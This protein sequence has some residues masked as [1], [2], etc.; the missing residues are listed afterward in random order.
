MLSAGSGSGSGAQNAGKCSFRSVGWRVVG[1]P[2]RACRV[3]ISRQ[4]TWGFVEKLE[5]KLGKN[6]GVWSCGTEPSIQRPEDQASNLPFREFPPLS[7]PP[8]S[9]H[10]VL[11]MFISQYHL[12][13][14]II[15]SFIY[16]IIFV[17]SLPCVRAMLKAS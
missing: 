12:F 4:D 14:I 16:S 13:I 1:A 9:N 3:C 7:Q 11:N 6:I 17:D 5:K 10:G 15:I 8:S 2:L